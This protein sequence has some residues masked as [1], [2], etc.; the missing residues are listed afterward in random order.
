MRALFRHLGARL[1]ASLCYLPCVI[2]WTTAPSS[3][4]CLMITTWNWGECEGLL[5]L[6]SEVVM[7]EHG[8][9]TV[10]GLMR[11]VTI[12]GSLGEMGIRFCWGHWTSLCW[13]GM[14]GL[15]VH[16]GRA[17]QITGKKSWKAWLVWKTGRTWI[18]EQARDLFIAHLAKQ[19]LFR[20]TQCFPIP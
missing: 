17:K 12:I 5:N 13:E 11:K 19:K 9:F 4:L 20:T 16:R 7:K 10:V 1:W 8:T 14:F 6:V 3:S 18:S 2:I 15:E